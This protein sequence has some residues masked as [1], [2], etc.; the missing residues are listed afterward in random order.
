MTAGNWPLHV[1]AVWRRWRRR[2]RMRRE[3]AALTARERRDVRLRWEDA[4]YEAC[5]PFWRE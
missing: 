5:K 2:A 3:L 4:V 1:A